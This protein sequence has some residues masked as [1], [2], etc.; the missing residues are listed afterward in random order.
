MPVDE[1]AQPNADTWAT[2]VKQVGNGA[3]ALRLAY[4]PPEQLD[5][6]ADAWLK[7]IGDTPGVQFWSDVDERASYL[8]YERPMIMPSWRR[9][10]PWRP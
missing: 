1:F 5:E 9:R 4:V 10:R 8:F 7:V 2:F 3:G 6:V